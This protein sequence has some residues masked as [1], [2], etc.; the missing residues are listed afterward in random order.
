MGFPTF[1]V[2]FLQS[3][4]SNVFSGSASVIDGSTNTVIATIN[5][6][7]L[8]EPAFDSN[9]CYILKPRSRRNN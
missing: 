4:T 2:L 6:Q 8:R 3:L 7:P 5:E 1:S 9:N